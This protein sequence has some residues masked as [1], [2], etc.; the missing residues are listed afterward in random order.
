VE[1]G[2]Y[3]VQ[4]AIDASGLSD[5][6]EVV[7]GDFLVDAIPPADVVTMA[8][9][10]HDWNLEQKMILIRK[11]Q[12]ALAPGG[13]A[14]IAVENEIDDARRENAFGL[15]MS[16][17]MLIEFGDASDYTAADFH[18]WCRGWFR[19][20]RDDSAGR[21][22]ERRGCVQSVASSVL[23]APAR[24][25]RRCQARLL[26][27]PGLE[28]LGFAALLRQILEITVLHGNVLQRTPATT[29]FAQIRTRRRP[30]D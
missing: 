5:R 27:D 23:R 24:R 7:S 21:A 15:L 1:T 14:P 20:F 13:G 16:L 6:I 26:T 4:D 17:N 12:D 2:Y 30:S 11:T 19:P 18:G 25:A 29:V 3:F 22:V 9:I 28:D 10:L 8:N